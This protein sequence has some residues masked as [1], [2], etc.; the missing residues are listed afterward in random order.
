M[1]LPLLWFLFRLSWA[2]LSLVYPERSWSWRPSTHIYVNSTEGRNSR[3][4]GLLSDHHIN[5]SGK[6]EKKLL[7]SQRQCSSGAAG[8]G[9]AS[10]T[11]TSPPKSPPRS[12]GSG[13]RGGSLEC[14]G[15]PSQKDLWGHLVLKHKETSRN[16]S[17]QVFSPEILV[18]LLGG[19]A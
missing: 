8:L 14:R 19:G 10:S 16:A 7:F 15:F 17:V 11:H 1:T 13:G 6:K 12:S 2:P 9:K 18:L 4:W 5:Q 3:F